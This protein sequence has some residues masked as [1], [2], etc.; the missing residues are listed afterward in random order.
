M[1]LFL[2]YVYKNQIG[3]FEIGHITLDSIV[4]A[5]QSSFKGKILQKPPAYSA[6]KQNGRRLS[7]LT[8]YF[9]IFY[10]ILFYYIAYIK[11]IE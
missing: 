1:A 6:L 9:S 10:F 8:R 11:D 7:D 3:N 2:N 5:L 4:N